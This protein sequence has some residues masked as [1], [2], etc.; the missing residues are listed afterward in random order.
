MHTVFINDFPLRFINA[1]DKKQLEFAKGHLI[2]SESNTQIEELIAELENSII[3]SEIFY[4]S[5]DE[6]AAWKL[7]I[8]YCT[9][10]EAAG[11]LVQ[12]DKDEYLVIFR[13]HK[14]DLPK[15]KLE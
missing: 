1:F 8:S 2:F 6:D 4:L 3:R 14:W 15:G 10:S 12:N 5:Q 9:L 13:H 7:F 11:G